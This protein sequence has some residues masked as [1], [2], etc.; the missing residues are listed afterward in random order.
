MSAVCRSPLARLRVCHSLRGGQ[1]RRYHR[2]RR[3]NSRSY[4]HFGP[5]LCFLRARTFRYY[6]FA[7]RKRGAQRNNLAGEE[8]ILPSAEMGYVLFAKR[9]PCSLGKYLIRA[10]ATLSTAFRFP[11]SGKRLR[12]KSGVKKKGCVACTYNTYVC[13]P[14]RRL[15]TRPEEFRLIEVTVIAAA[16]L[17]S[18]GSICGFG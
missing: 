18:S 8:N 7:S 5:S 12:L 3:L 16:P 11:H 13:A 17:L 2:H 6:S 9:F 10:G 4:F 1:S 14:A 15:L